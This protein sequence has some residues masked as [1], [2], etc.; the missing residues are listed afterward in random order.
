MDIKKYWVSKPFLTN[1]CKSITVF[2]IYSQSGPSATAKCQPHQLSVT[3]HSDSLATLLASE[4]AWTVPGREC[5]GTSGNNVYLTAC[6]YLLA[7]NMFEFAEACIGESTSYSRMV[8]FIQK[9][10]FRKK[11]PFFKTTKLTR[12]SFFNF[13]SALRNFFI[14]LLTGEYLREN[15]QGSVLAH[16]YLS[17]SHFKQGNYHASLSHL[18]GMAKPFNKCLPVLVLKFHNVYSLWKVEKR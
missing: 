15:P 16:Y 6:P 18:K 8:Q 11:T 10:T 12:V 13:N 3:K 14:H 17:V 4:L 5:C 7:L 2:Q 9:K 1:N